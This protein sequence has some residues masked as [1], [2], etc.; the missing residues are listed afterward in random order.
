MVV[1]AVAMLAVMVAM[2]VHVIR[3][4]VVRAAALGNYERFQFVENRFDL[5]ESQND[6]CTLDLVVCSPEIRP[7]IAAA[8]GGVVVGAVQ[9]QNP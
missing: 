6:L 7:D 4:V 5:I 1:V 8:A 9:Q 2:V 3:A